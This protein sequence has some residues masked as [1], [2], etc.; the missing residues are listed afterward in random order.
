MVS[1]EVMERVA[2][3]SG[4]AVVGGGLG[5]VA[6]WRSR[7]HKAEIEF[8]F[9]EI[10]ASNDLD[11]AIDAAAAEFACANGRPELARLLAEKVRVAARVGVRAAATWQGD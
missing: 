1:V 3:V 8:A 10:P 11:A 9:D 7:S 5:F 6:G 2:A 4:A